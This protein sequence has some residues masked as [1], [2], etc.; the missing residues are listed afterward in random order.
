MK[1][2]RSS[3]FIYLI[4]T[5]SL[6]HTA[7]ASDTQAAPG[8]TY[9]WREQIQHAI[10]ADPQILEENRFQNQYQN[11][12]RNKSMEQTGFKEMGADGRDRAG[13]NHNAHQNR[14]NESNGA[15]NQYQHR[16]QYQYRNGGQSDMQI[17]GGNSGSGKGRH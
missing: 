6:A 5:L 12:Y 1:L 14:Y 2:S 17:R 11:Q 8:N 16:N 4:T 13:Q 9:Q 10:K 3:N 7:H 15:G